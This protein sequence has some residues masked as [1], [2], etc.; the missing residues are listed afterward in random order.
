M[1]VDSSVAAVL[2]HKAIGKQLNCIFIDTGLLRKSQTTA[3]L[4][5]IPINYVDKSNLFLSRLKG[6]TDP[7]EKRKIIGNTFIEVF[8]EEAKNR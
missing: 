8:E 4:K 5:E 2:T 6:I 3:M 1:G 7:E